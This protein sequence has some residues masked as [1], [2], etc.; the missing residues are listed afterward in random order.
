M[1]QQN[2]GSGFTM[3]EMLIVMAIFGV[4]AAVAFPSYQEYRQRVL[5][6]Q[7][8]ADLTEIAQRLEKFKA[9]N[10][11]Y[12]EYLGDLGD[13]PL[14]PWGNAYYYLNLAD[15]DPN[16]GQVKTGNKGPKPRAR[17]KKNLKPLNT[18]FDLFSAGADGDY[19]ANVSARA[20]LDDVIRADDGAYLGLA[21]Q[22]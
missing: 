13:V 15:V 22:Y 21:S 8:Q 9:F 19:R 7:A 14:D 2:A 20:S 17:K 10:Y 3:V 12:P 1:Y 5:V 11:A 6:A 4:L 16:S 18:D